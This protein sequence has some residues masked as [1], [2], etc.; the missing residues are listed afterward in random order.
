MFEV[1]KEARNQPRA[2]L[3]VSDGKC[4]PLVSIDSAN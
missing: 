2:C 3:I 1:A 4:A